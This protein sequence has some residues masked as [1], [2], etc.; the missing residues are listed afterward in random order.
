MNATP[1]RNNN[2]ENFGTLVADVM[3]RNMAGKQDCLV[4]G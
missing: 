3:Y 2:S 4:D 1:S